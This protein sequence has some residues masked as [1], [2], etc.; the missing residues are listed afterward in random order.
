MVQPDVCIYAVAQRR[1]L[2]G[3]RARL[4]T[5]G[6]YVCGGDGAIREKRAVSPH[7]LE[8][9]RWDAARFAGVAAQD[10]YAHRPGTWTVAGGLLVLPTAVIERIEEAEERDRWAMG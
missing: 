8:M 7:M 3:R 2:L 10:G 5:P 4:E 9:H 6:G 1:V